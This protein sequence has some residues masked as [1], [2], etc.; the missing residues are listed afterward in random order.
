MV[1]EN[2]RSIATEKVLI[3]H[4]CHNSESILNF[5]NALTIMNLYE[6]FFSISKRFLAKTCRMNVILM[7]IL[8]P[9]LDI[10]TKPCI[11]NYTM[12]FMFFN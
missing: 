5:I 1:L 4:I 3:Q 12:T 8:N 2:L 11:I 10:A 6:G 7:F 9:V